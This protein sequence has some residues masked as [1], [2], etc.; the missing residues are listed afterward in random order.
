MSNVVKVSWIFTLVYVSLTFIDSIVCKRIVAK[1][2]QML[3]MNENQNQNR[4][5]FWIPENFL[6][7]RR[8]TILD[9]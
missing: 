9:L 6:S 8:M 7:K 4:A 1:Q 5:G 2:E 3:E